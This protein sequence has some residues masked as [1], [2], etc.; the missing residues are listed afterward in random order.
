M[1]L[2]FGVYY[3]RGGDVGLFHVCGQILLLLFLLFGLF[4]VF[5]VVGA[6]GFF[7]REVGDRF[8]WEAVRFASLH[9][10]LFARIVFVIIL[11]VVRTV[12][13]SELEVVGVV[14]Q[15]FVW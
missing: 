7:G 1:Q 2:T 6:F 4:V 13:G 15:G 9:Y 12:A 8:G 5:E 14:A 10:A 3:R 11:G